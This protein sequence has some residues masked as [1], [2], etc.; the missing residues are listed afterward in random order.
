V[1]LLL[2]IA[3]AAGCQRDDAGAPSTNADKKSVPIESRY[4]LTG[5]VRRIDRAAGLLTLRHDEIPG[6][7]PAMTM[8]FVVQDH[9]QLDELQPGDRV[10]ATLVVKGEESR[11]VDVTVTEWADPGA[12]ADQDRA[13]AVLKPGNDVPDFT[14][15][16][17][18]GKQL[19][20]SELKGNVVVFTFIYT[21]CPLPDYCPAV[22]RKFAELSRRVQLLGAAADRVRLLSISFDPEHDTPEVLARHAAIVGAKPPA[23]MFCV[24]SHEELRRIAPSLGLSYGPVENEIIH[25]LSTAVVDSDGKLAALEL[26][27]GWS[28]D[29]VFSLVREALRARKP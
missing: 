15:T 18:E 14:L 17:Q 24:A 20:L 26:G 5:Q 22:D 27:K 9:A 2:T 1:I 25:T 19:R 13:N 21:R 6:Y 12:Q 4:A 16:T 29:Q 7:M 10:R 3:C 28:V 8:P 23:W 11:L